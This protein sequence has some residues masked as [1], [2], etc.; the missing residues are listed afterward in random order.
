MAPRVCVHTGVVASW[1]PFPQSRVPPARFA[2]LGHLQKATPD[3]ILQAF[4]PKV[5]R[6]PFAP[7]SAVLRKKIDQSRE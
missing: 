6:D 1:T 3:R 7:P 4:Q 2:G 5:N